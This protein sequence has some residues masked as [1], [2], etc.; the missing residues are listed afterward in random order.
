MARQ[1]LLILD[2]TW[3]I[4]TSNDAGCFCL[5]I[6]CT[7][8]EPM[9]AHAFSFAIFTWLLLFCGKFF[10]CSAQEHL[11]RHTVS[12]TFLCLELTVLFIGWTKFLNFEEYQF[13]MLS[14]VDQIFLKLCLRKLYLNLFKFFFYFPTVFF[15]LL[16]LELNYLDYNV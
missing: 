7:C 12:K 3:E 1:H 6:I 14:I 16:N 4:L 9:R 13:L 5:L 10:A 8:Y 15:F 2:F 11:I